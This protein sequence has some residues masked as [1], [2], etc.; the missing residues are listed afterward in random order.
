[1]D[2]CNIKK[3][4]NINPKDKSVIILKE[5]IYIHSKY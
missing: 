2:K 1:M 3:D 5:K 4:V